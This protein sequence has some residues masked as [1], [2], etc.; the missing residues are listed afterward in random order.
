MATRGDIVTLKEGAYDHS[1]NEVLHPEWSYEYV[2]HSVNGNQLSVFPNYFT[3]NHPYGYEYDAQIDWE[4][5][6]DEFEFIQFVDVDQIIDTVETNS[7]KQPYVGDRVLFDAD[8][9]ACLEGV[10]DAVIEIGDDDY[11]NDEPL[12]AIHADI[13][14][15]NAYGTGVEH[16]DHV[17]S[18]QGIIAIDS[19][20]RDS[21]QKCECDG[22]LEGL[23]KFQRKVAR[24]KRRAERRPFGL[25]AFL[26]LVYAITLSVLLLYLVDFLR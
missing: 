4:G 14:F 2:V 10:V 18:R 8:N 1:D 3:T 6:W 11:E 9:G 21:Y 12:Y 5:D 25:P 17:E 15:D 23:W 16:E 13:P 26:I 22:T 20:E 19:S 24:E 7:E